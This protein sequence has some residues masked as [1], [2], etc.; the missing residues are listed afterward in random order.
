MPILLQDWGLFNLYIIYNII[1]CTLLLLLWPG[2][3]WYMHR[4][5]GSFEGL[6]ERLGWG[7]PR[8]QSGVENRSRTTWFHGASVGEVQMLVPLISA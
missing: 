5:Q 7:W 1:L 8:C 3:L 6:G 4:R 2:L